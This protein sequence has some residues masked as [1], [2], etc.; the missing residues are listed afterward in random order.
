MLLD[1]NMPTKLDCYKGKDIFSSKKAVRTEAPDNKIIFK[2][3]AEDKFRYH[4]THKNSHE[5]W[6]VFLFIT[7]VP[8]LSSVQERPG[9][10]RISQDKL[11]RQIF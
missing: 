6:E 9:K 11:R 2:A 1:K 4:K 5:S 3:N 10:K 7:K 8:P